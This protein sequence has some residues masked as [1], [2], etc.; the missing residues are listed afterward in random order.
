M[1]ALTDHSAPS[2][3]DY[4][5]Q[6]SHSSIPLYAFMGRVGQLYFYVTSR[7]KSLKWLFHLDLLIKTMDSFPCLT[8]L[9]LITLTILGESRG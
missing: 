1:E 6:W 4:K 3:A 5:E 2:S 9:Y 8:H 7:P